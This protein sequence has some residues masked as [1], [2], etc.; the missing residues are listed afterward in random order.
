MKNTSKAELYIISGAIILAL[1][2]FA[3]F[4]VMNRDRPTSSTLLNASSTAL[5]V[6]PTSEATTTASSKPEKGPLKPLGL[7]KLT[8]PATVKALILGDSVAESLG[9]SNKNLTSWNALVANDL[10]AKYPGTVEWNY[11]TTKEATID[12]ALKTL[13]EG[14]QATDLI[15]LCVGRNDGAILTTDD[16]KQKYEQ[17]IAELKVKS[18]HTDLFLVVEP[19]VKNLATNNKTFPY[20]QVILD[21]GEKYKLPVIDEWSAFLND[22]TPL[23][24]LLSY[25][26]NPNDKGYRI[27]ANAVVKK[28]EEV[29]ASK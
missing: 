23:S 16:F 3:Y 14:T 1:I 29:L 24:K 7:A 18:P 17:F 20:R 9:A 15:I 2:V 8:G 12:D 6:P 10:H 4:W 11:K 26:V 25:G 19:P 21:L 22:P 13:P 28:F 27:F 5:Y